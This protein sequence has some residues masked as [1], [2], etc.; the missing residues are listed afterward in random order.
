MAANLA[1]SPHC[2]IIRKLDVTHRTL[3]VPH[4]LECVTKPQER[5]ARQPAPRLPFENMAKTQKAWRRVKSTSSGR[6]PSGDFW[7]GGC[8]GTKAQA[9]G[10]QRVKGYA[11]LAE[12]A[13]RIRH[14][15]RLPL[16]GS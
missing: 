6:A 4:G 10:R 7:N 9:F 16:A 8:T 5:I 2:L 3:R 13:S 15:L 14:K 11:E 1:Q 12:E